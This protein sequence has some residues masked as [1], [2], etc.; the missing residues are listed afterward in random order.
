MVVKSKHTP[1]QSDDLG[2]AITPREFMV[3]EH[4]SPS[5]YAKMRRMGTAPREFIIPGT[6]IRRITPEAHREW[7][8]L[9]AVYTAS[10]AARLEEARRSVQAS[11]AGKIAAQSP[12]HVSKRKLATQADK[13]GKRKVKAL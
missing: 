8:Q 11:Q 10:T 1:E 9:M 4:L 3:A 12:L 5:S 6:R 7:R 2:R 13:A